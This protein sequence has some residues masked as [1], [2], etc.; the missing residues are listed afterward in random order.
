[1]DQSE[2]LLVATVQDDASFAHGAETIVVDVR[3]EQNGCAAFFWKPVDG[4]TLTATIAS[5]TNPSRDGG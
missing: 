2:P 4:H 5:I 3:A 1:M